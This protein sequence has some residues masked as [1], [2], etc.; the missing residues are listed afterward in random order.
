VLPRKAGIQFLAVLY[1]LGHCMYSSL[2]R[3]GWLFRWSLDTNS[4]PL[5][6][7]NNI[8]NPIICLF[9]F[10]F[11]CWYIVPHFGDLMY[12]TEIFLR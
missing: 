10:L 5:F 12:K 4:F 9:S 2:S 3:C 6:L 7:D 11:L 1:A 8:C